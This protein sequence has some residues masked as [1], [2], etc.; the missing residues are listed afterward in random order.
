MTSSGEFFTS[1]R[2]A[3]IITGKKNL[4]LLQ[5]ETSA[6]QWTSIKTMKKA[7]QLEEENICYRQTRRKDKKFLSRIC[8]QNVKKSNLKKIQKALSKYFIHT[9]KFQWPINKVPCV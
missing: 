2:K 4:T 9:Q 8:K 1:L 7:A 3:L 6:H 5:T